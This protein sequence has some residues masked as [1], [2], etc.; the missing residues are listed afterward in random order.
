MIILRITHRLI[1]NSRLRFDLRAC[2]AEFTSPQ[3]LLRHHHQY[4]SELYHRAFVAGARPGSNIQTMH[5]LASCDAFCSIQSSHVDEFFNLSQ[6]VEL[7]YIYMSKVTK[8]AET[9]FVGMEV[10]QLME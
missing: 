10:D 1:S 2:R 8:M 5:V 3:A 9:I 6:S 4:Q 7:G